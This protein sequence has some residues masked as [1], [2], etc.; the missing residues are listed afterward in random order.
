M[1]G[2]PSSLFRRMFISF[3]VTVLLALSVVGMVIY[4]LTKE[5]I[6]ADQ[7]QLMLRQAK[8][9]NVAIQQSSE[10]NEDVQQMITFLD[11]SYN[12]RIW[13]FDRDGLIQATSWPDEVLVDT[14]IALG[15]YSKRVAHNDK[16]E[17]DEL[18]LMFNRMAEKLE[19]I[20]LE[21][22]TEEERRNHFIASISHELRTPL[23]AMQGFLEAL[24]DGLVQGE[25]ARE[26]YYAIMFRE[27]MYLNRLVD[28]LMDL[29]KLERGEV[30]LHPYFVNIRELVEKI[31]FTLQNA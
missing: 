30:S 4:L 16:D 1:N 11:Q 13:L 22:R 24:Q 23:T 18:S 28:D 20:D 6:F 31:S 9:V 14:E 26:R 25:E 15:N 27:T 21:R 29:I 12:S 19:T 7:E 17:I 3:L 5:Q 10:I 2:F 8:Q